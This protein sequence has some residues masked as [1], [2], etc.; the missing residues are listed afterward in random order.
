MFLAGS[1]RTPTLNARE[2]VGPHDSEERRRPG[3]TALVREGRLAPGLAADDHVGLHF[4]GT[5]LGE[6]VTSVAGQAAYRVD[7][8]GES[9]LDA[10]VL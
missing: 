3:Y 4:A 6:V 1:G 7:R 5:E 2:A 8:D 10:T 9:R